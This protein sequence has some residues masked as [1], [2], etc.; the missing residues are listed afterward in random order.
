LSALSPKLITLSALPPGVTISKKAAP[1]VVLI[2]SFPS[3]TS[4]FSVGELV[5]IPNLPSLVISHSF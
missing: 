1:E 4:N 5:P 3:L 2:K